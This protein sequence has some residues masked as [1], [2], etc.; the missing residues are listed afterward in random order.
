[1]P[2]EVFVK[3]ILVPLLLLYFVILYLYAFK[4]M[5][6]WELPKGWVSSLISVLAVL[7]FVIHIVIYPVR[8]THSSLLLRRFHPWFF[9]LLAQ[10]I[11]LLFIAV[12]KRLN[13]YGFTEA[14]YLL[15]ALSFWILSMILYF[16][17]SKKKELRILPISV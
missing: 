8:K 11:L 1:K 6:D 7:G 10:L 15:L 9:I 12:G 3:N 5:I 2:L 4:I 14:R 13:E 17:F 16:L